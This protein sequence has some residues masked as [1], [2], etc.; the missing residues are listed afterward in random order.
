MDCLGLAF[1]LSTGTELTK[2]RVPLTFR[3]Y[4]SLTASQHLGKF[5]IHLERPRHASDAEVMA[6]LLA[7]QLFFWKLDEIQQQ[8]LT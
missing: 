7:K 2:S 1:S 4:F 8:Q 5:P 6:N 3:C